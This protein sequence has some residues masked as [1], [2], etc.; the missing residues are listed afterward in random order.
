MKIILFFLFTFI[1]YVLSETFGPL[2]FA[3]LMPPFKPPGTEHRFFKNLV[4][5]I[6]NYDDI[7]LFLTKGDTRS[8]LQHLSD[9]CEEL[10]RVYGDLSKIGDAVKSI[11]EHQREACQKL[12][13]VKEDLCRDQSDTYDY[14]MTFLLSGTD[15]HTAYTKCRLR[16]R[17]CS[18]E[19]S[20]KCR[21]LL[22]ICNYAYNEER[23]HVLL[24]N[25]LDDFTSESFRGK[26]KKLC[27]E[28]SFLGDHFVRLCLNPDSLQSLLPTIRDSLRKS[29]LPFRS[30]PKMSMGALLGAMKLDGG[31]YSPKN[32]PT[33]DPSYFMGYLL[34]QLKPISFES[35]C[36]EICQR[37]LGLDFFS[38]SAYF[39]D[40]KTTASQNSV[41]AKTRVELFEQHIPNLKKELQNKLPDEQYPE[42]VS[43]SGIDV[44]L[45]KKFLGP[46]SYLKDLDPTLY[47]LCDRLKG[48]CVFDLEIASSLTVYE[49]Y[50]RKVFLR[51]DSNTHLDLCQKVLPRI[52]GFT[53]NTTVDFLTFCLNPT[54]TCFSLAALVSLRCDRIKEEMTQV[55]P[56]HE[57]CVTKL[58]EAET[59]GSLCTEN[60]EYV[61]FLTICYNKNPLDEYLKGLADSKLKK[62]TPENKFGKLDDGF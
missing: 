30:Y 18:S 26:L 49:Y 17:G 10:T 22:S 38:Q 34:G 28:L 27:N 21:T 12:P 55:D 29:S 15:C 25:S 46:C 4:S 45:C 31:L 41:C 62:S 9:A 14:L 51:K 2:G 43:L 19:L 59:Y 32:N 47:S 54:H 20:R 52:C 24:V 11:C 37:C 60:E 8:C 36:I 3:T 6:Y 53:L 42:I 35:D 56:S 33:V 57:D 1:T 39:C 16:S 48:H 44:D 40:A 58:R 50:F 23:F 7:L 5:K 13:K 61:K